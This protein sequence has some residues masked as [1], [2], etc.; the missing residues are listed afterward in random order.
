MRTVAAVSGVHVSTVSRSLRRAALGQPPL[1]ENDVRI[2]QVAEELDYV[3]NPNAAS[4][5]TKRSNTFGVLVPSLTDTTLAAIYDSA[6]LTAKRRGFETF[7]VNTHDDPKEQDRRIRL[8]TG[9]QVD[10]LLLGDARMDGTNLGELERAGI[11]FVLVLRRS[12]GYLSVT[13]DDFRGGYLAG[14]HLIGLGHRAIGIVAGPAWASTSTDRVDGMRA[15]VADA[16]FE[17]APEYVV[18]CGFQVEDGRRGA[19]RLLS[20][21]VPPTAIFAV[22]DISAIGVL[23]QLRAHSIRPGHDIAVV[24]YNDLAMAAELTVPLTTLRNPLDQIGRIAVEKLLDLID[25]K[26]AESTKLQPRLMV[27]ESTVP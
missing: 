7:V 18:E 12:E 6:E 16:G 9:R 10:G 4:L 2:R 15:A 21:P 14:Q 1:N 25:G 22:N 20:L 26:P 27:R 23:G 11:R 13:G 8:L 19:A 5:K 3:F 17:I 24:G